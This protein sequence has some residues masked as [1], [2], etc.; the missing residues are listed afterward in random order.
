[1]EPRD[2]EVFL[3]P[4][5]WM[6]VASRDIDA[7]GRILRMIGRIRQTYTFGGREWTRPSEIGPRYS[8]IVLEQVTS[9]GR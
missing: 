2:S 9:N 8:D 3:F 4:F 1:L 5:L 7:F 6:M